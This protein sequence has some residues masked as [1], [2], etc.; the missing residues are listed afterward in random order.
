MIGFS[1][2]VGSEFSEFDVRGE[3]GLW[4]AESCGEELSGLSGIVVDGLFAHEDELWFESSSQFGEDAG[5]VPGVQRH[6]RIDADCSVGSHGQ[7]RA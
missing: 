4:P 1:S 6:G 7:S 2:H 5:N 3:G